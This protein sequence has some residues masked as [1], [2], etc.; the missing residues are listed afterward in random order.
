[1]SAT[2]TV[3]GAN[4]AFTWTASTDN[5]GVTGYNFR[6]GATSDL[7]GE[8]PTALVTNSHSLESLTAGTYYWQVRAVDAKGNT[9]AWA[10]A[11][12]FVVE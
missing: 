1:M 2:E 7:S 8:T 10:S 11:E 5:V 6:S 3:T 9:S 4:V 12:S